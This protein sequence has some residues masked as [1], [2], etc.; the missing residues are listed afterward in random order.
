MTCFPSLTLL[1]GLSPTKCIPTRKSFG[2]AGTYRPA[3]FLAVNH[4]ATY[5]A[6][7]TD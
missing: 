5:C 7:A 3:T 4:T 2:I 6:H 1:I